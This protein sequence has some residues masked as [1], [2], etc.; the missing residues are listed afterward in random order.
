MLVIVFLENFFYLHTI[1]CICQREAVHSVLVNYCPR[2][3]K[4]TESFT[5]L[6]PK[7]VTS[8]VLKLSSRMLVS[9]NSQPSATTVVQTRSESEKVHFV[10]S[11]LTCSFSPNPTAMTSS[12]ITD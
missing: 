12:T 1:F 5:E 8:I 6:V 7:A 3:A 11:V 10:K 2:F 4:V 9:M